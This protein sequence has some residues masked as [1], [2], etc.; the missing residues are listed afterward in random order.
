MKEV[1]EEEDYSVSL[2]SKSSIWTLDF[3]FPIV[4]ISMGLG[5]MS[6]L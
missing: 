5:F 2:K 1:E 4:P 3:F 6:Q